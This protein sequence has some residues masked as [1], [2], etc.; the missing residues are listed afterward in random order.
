MT[1]VRQ[2][3]AMIRAY[4][5]IMQTRLGK[6]LAWSVD[7]ADDVADCTIPPGM[8]ITLTENAIKHG[9]EPAAR[10]GRVDVSV[11]RDGSNV[12]L[13][14][15]DTGAGFSSGISAGGI[16]LANIRERLALLYGDNASLALE[17]NEPRGF[18]ARIILP[19]ARMAHAVPVDAFTRELAS[20]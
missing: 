16:G 11:E 3:A 20:R 1:T 14:V 9:I 15:C 19:A 2:E 5:G 17:E 12:S 13:L 6:R 7:V 10:G 4:L 8:V 18:R